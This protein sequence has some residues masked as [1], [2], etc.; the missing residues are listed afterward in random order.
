MT[1]FKKKKG[2]PNRKPKHSKSKDRE[3][4]RIRTWQVVYEGGVHHLLHCKRGSEAPKT[5]NNSVTHQVTSI[6][7]T[8]VLPPGNFTQWKYETYTKS[9]IPKTDQLRDSTVCPTSSGKNFTACQS[10]DDW[11]QKT[12]G[13]KK[14]RTTATTTIHHSPATW[15]TLVTL[16]SINIS[17][18]I[19]DTF[20]RTS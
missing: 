7:T 14:N 10:S 9:T 19:C 15:S 5:E 16:I 13:S 2:Q 11:L 4:C 8:L 1:D 17:G 18:I 6:F 20:P 12:I 3:V